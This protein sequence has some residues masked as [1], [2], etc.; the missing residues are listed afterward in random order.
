MYNCKGGKKTEKSYFLP[1][2]MAVK[3]CCALEMN[4]GEE[5]TCEALDLQ[6]T[7]KPPVNEGEMSLL[8]ST[9]WKNM[10]N[11]VPQSKMQVQSGMR[12]AIWCCDLH[13][14]CAVCAQILPHRPCPTTQ[15]MSHLKD[16]V[17]PHSV[18]PQRWYHASQ[19][20]SHHTDHVTPH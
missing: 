4:D 3:Q 19:T 12:R 9:R 1:F 11:V 7:R 10:D 5:S 15:T 13:S 17:T 20:V 14:V 6:E 18:T 2:E 8:T 16:L